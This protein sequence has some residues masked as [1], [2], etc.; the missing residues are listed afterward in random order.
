MWYGY[1]LAVLLGFVLGWLAALPFGNKKIT[2]LESDLVHE[3]S[4]NSKEIEKL[5]GEKRYMSLEIEKLKGEKANA[6]KAYH[7]VSEILNES[8]QREYL[9]SIKLDTS[10]EGNKNE[11]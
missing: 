9:G 3:S 10:K 2:D 8:A 4:K 5:I 1:L 11:R 7:E 6:E